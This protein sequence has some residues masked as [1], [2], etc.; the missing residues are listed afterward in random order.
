MWILSEVATVCACGFKA[1]K[2]KV[3]QRGVFI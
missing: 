1:S 2:V 3:L